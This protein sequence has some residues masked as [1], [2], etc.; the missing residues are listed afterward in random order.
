MPRRDE[1]L[2][3][4]RGEV[5]DRIPYTYEALPETEAKLR[6]YL[7]A[8]PEEK[9]WQRFGASRFESLWAAVGR[10]P[11]MPERKAHNARSDPTVQIDYWGVR[12]ERV[13]AGDAHYFEITQAPLTEAETVADVE[14]YDW[15]RVE[16]MVWPETPVDRDWA[17]WKRQQDVVILDMSCIGPFGITWQMFGLERALTNIVLA[18]EL[19]EAAVAK[20]EAFTLGCLREIFRRYP[21]AVDAVGCGDDYGTQNGLLLGPEPIRHLFMPSLKPALRPGAGARG[22]G[23]SPFMRRNFRHHSGADRGRRAGA[24]PHSDLCGRHGS[25]APQARIRTP[26]LFPRGH[27]HPADACDGHPGRGARRGQRSHRHPRPR[28][29]HPGSL[30]RH[31]ARLA[32]GQHCRD[33]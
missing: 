31:A 19:M 8:R 17:A 7:G 21:G 5:P 13:T 28:R 9:L 29:L 2:A 27:R 26:T 24:Q 30:A 6:A 15:P 32:I 1:M 16:E 23:L 33:V 4:M 25:G 3:A 12:R 22:D 14:A 20:V 18:P 11:S 10:G